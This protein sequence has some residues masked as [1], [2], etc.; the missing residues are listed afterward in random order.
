MLSKIN[1]CAVFGLNCFLVDIEVD[2]FRGKPDFKVVGLGDTAIQE[3][4]ARV[5]SAI[6]NSD[7]FYPW[8]KRVLI[9]LAPADLRKEGPSFDLPMALGLIQ[10]TEQIIFNYDF[11][12]S[13][14]IGELALDGSVR[15]VNGVLPAAIYAREQGLKK[16]FL[17]QA[18]AYEA[19]LIGDIEIYPVENL[20]QVID[21]LLGVRLIEK[22]KIDDS[23]KQKFLAQKTEFDMK[24]VKGQEHV[25]RAMEIASAGAHNLL[26][27]GPPGSGKTLLAR[28]FPTILPK[29]T[30]NEILEVTKIYS[31]AGMLDADK[32]LIVHRPFRSPHHSSSS[33][34]LVGGGRVPS[35]G[36]IS[37]SHRGVL[38]LDELLEFPRPVLESLRQPLE[39]GVVSIS[40]AQGTLT[41][42]ARFILICSMNPCPCGYLNDSEQKCTCSAMQVANYQKKISGP[43]LDRIDM[44][45]EVP[46]V[47]FE[48]LT[49]DQLAEPSQSIQQRVQNARE[50]QEYRFKDSTFRTNAEMSTKEIKYYCKLNDQTVELLRNAV[51]QMNLSARSYYRV[52]KLSR[53]IADLE[54]SGDIELNHVAE[55]LQY[56]P[57]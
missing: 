50:I 13:L 27:S 4:R 35:P 49:S 8:N 53:T 52:L 25:K 22:F 31:I 28:T 48:K 12:N 37:L 33:A 9:N 32:P 38:F 42:P 3:A 41:F 16:I 6:S 20:S 55:A 34:A 40:R 14:F 43:L 5:R 21:H 44:H 19:S 7:F 23:E 26:M 57:K 54:N 45:L 46:R 15:H 36:E 56:R 1:S 24:Y 11:S 10:A 18:D 30:K 17:P 51:K 29:I 39:D 47:K 2:V